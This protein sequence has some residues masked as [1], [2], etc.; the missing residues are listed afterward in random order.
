M[1]P[2]ENKIVSLPDLS[3]LNSL[4]GSAQFLIGLPITILCLIVWWIGNR[5]KTAPSPAPP[6]ATA[7]PYER[8]QFWDGPI[9]RFLKTVER[10]AIS[11]EK[12]PTSN[13]DLQEMADR[14]RESRHAMRGEIQQFNMHAEA[15]I[16]KL[17]KDM[18]DELRA[19]YERLRVIGEGLAAIQGARRR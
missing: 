1:T 11:V 16:E 10:I 12:I 14:I 19:I 2:Q 8:Q 18:R 13:E 17:E 9:E 15:D 3:P 7:P 4:S 5:H 6:P